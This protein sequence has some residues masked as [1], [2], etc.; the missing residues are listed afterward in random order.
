MIRECSLEDISD[1]RTYGLNDMVKLDTAGCAGCYKCCTGMGNSIV[2]DPYDVWLLK[3]HLDKSFQ[4]LLDQKFIELNMVDGLILPNLTMGEN[5]RCSFLNEAGRCSIHTARPGICRLFPLGRVYDDTGFKYFLQKG[6]C[7]KEAGAKVKVKKWIDTDQ[8]D[9][10]QNFIFR[11]HRFIRYAGNKI[12][13]LK[14][15]GQSESVNDIAMFVLNSFFI[16]DF[17]LEQN[18]TIYDSIGLRLEKAQNIIKETF[19]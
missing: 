1:G 15:Q 10:N 19:A 4:E 12:I 9:E 18:K 14:G 7:A 13:S 5:N 11:W 3:S 17:S 2:L 6:E 8:I 16:S